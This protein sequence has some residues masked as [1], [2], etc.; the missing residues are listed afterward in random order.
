MSEN[1]VNEAGNEGG[2][3]TVALPEEGEMVQRVAGAIFL[4]NGDS[5]DQAKA[6]LRAM[7]NYKGEVEEA[8]DRIPGGWGRGS[9][10]V[11]IA[12]ALGEEP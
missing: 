8:L 1:T 12:A 11:G 9:W 4:T 10:I 5:I 7:K 3:V 6:A 2:S